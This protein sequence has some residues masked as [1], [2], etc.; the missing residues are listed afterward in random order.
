MGVCKLFRILIPLDVNRNFLWLQ[1]ANLSR[2]QLQTTMTVNLNSK[3]LNTCLP[4][5]DVNVTA[6]W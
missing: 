3:N 2:L 4:F 1:N 5:A 6:G